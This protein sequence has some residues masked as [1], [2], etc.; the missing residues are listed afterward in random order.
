MTSEIISV[1]AEVHA[2]HMTSSSDHMTPSLR[3][4]V[5]SLP[6]VHKRSSSASSTNDTPVVNGRPPGVTAREKLKFPQ[7]RSSKPQSVQD[8]IAIP[9]LVGVTS[10]LGQEGRVTQLKYV[11]SWQLCANSLVLIYLFFSYQDQCIRKQQN[12]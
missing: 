7:V 12:Q 1:T 2:D 11:R 9:A 6:D 5:P 4:N 10:T 8:N 3:D